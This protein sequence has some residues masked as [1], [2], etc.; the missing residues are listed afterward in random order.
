MKYLWG[1]EGEG[2][3]D[4]FIENS[5]KVSSV[6]VKLICSDCHIYLHLAYDEWYLGFKT[7]AWYYRQF[8]CMLV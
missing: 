6:F 5:P 1:R 2:G 3:G 7:T 4:T 8:T